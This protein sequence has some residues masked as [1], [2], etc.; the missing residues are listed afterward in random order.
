MALLC[1]DE[2]CNKI[3]SGSPEIEEPLFALYYA[4]VL[5]REK[6]YEQLDTLTKVNPY[7]ALF[8]YPTAIQMKAQN[9]CG[10][11]FKDFL[12]NVIIDARAFESY[13]GISEAIHQFATTTISSTRKY[14]QENGILENAI[15]SYCPVV[16][17]S[18]ELKYVE[19]SMPMV[20]DPISDFPKMYSDCLENI[21]TQIKVLSHLASRAPLAIIDT[22]GYYGTGT[23][24]A[25]IYQDLKLQ[26][27][28]MQLALMYWGLVSLLTLDEPPQP[29]DVTNTW[30]SMASLW[31]TTPA[32][33]ATF[34]NVYDALLKDTKTFISTEGWESIPDNHGA[35]VE[36]EYQN[37]N[38]AACFNID[39]LV[40][41][42]HARRNVTTS[43]GTTTYVESEWP[44][45][46]IT[47]ITAFN[48]EITLITFGNTWIGIPFVDIA[49]DY[50]IKVMCIN[51]NG[52]LQDFTSPPCP[53]ND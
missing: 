20:S 3:S 2:I 40:S 38:A 22:A 21:A 26:D 29:M 30:S 6:R 8:K 15:V 27:E 52:D 44:N 5:A 24:V 41:E 11:D 49:D 32:E 18:Q 48:D 7:A 42:F 39:K 53:N 14:Q 28:K 45:A 9:I 17:Y 23:G 46:G 25:N 16:P 4:P 47:D 50:T 31:A 34:E 10:H 19:G 1:L 36:N 51:Q 12:K 33:K 43:P 37:H 13:E 35:L